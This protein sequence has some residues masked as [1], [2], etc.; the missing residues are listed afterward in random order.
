GRST[1]SPVRNRLWC[2]MRRARSANSVRTAGGMPSRGVLGRNRGG[3]SNTPCQRVC[4]T[5]HVQSVPLR[6][7]GRTASPTSD[8]VWKRA[9][10]SSNSISG[11]VGATFSAG[12]GVSAVSQP[13]ATRQ[14]RAGRHVSHRGP[15]PELV[16]D[17]PLLAS[18]RLWLG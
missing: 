8:P 6:L 16:V 18:A 4:R 17:V 9:Q 13:L 7:G 15:L 11:R 14:A 10:H 5:S 12:L 1:S 3:G 2:A